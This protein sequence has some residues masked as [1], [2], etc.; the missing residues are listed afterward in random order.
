[1]AAFS[2]EN[3]I[4]RIVLA[5]VLIVFIMSLYYDSFLETEPLF[6]GK[7]TAWDTAWTIEIDGQT[8]AEEITLPY[9]LPK[10]VK[11]K[12]ITLHYTI[13]SQLPAERRTIAFNS[14]MASV[15]VKVNDEALYSFEGPQKGW[16]VPVFGGTYTHFIRLEEAHLGGELSITFGYTS[17]NSFAGHFKPVYNGTKTDLLFHELREWPSLFYGFSLL[18]IGFLV[19][20]FSLSIQTDEERKSFFYFGLVLLAL[21]GWVFSQT[22]SKFLLFR[23]PALPM[24]L[25]FAALFLLPL[26]LVNYIIH[27]YPVGKWVTP[28]LYISHFFASIYVLGGALQLFG[29]TQY[30]DLLLPCGVFLALFLL[31]LFTLLFVEYYRGNQD[32]RSFLVAMGLLLSSILAEV[33][34]LILGISLDSAVILHFGMAASAVV[35]FWRSATLMR[36][37][38]KSICKEQLLLSLAYSDALT[39]VGNRAAYDREVSRIQTSKDKQVLGILMMDVNDL[40][41]INDT[42][43]HTQG[44]LVLRD[45]AR[46]LQ[47]L[48]PFRAKIYRYGGDEFI[49]LISDVSEEEMQKLADRILS[50]FPFG[51]KLHYFVAV[52]FDRYIPKRKDRFHQCVGRADEAMYACKH[53]MKQPASVT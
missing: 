34:L 6:D 10:P 51:N 50:P 26:F 37:K 30:T 16:A 27:S 38:T 44:D 19:L 1:M 13:P 17:N 7:V 43:G 24:N 14:S 33:I 39:E 41:K 28:F 36:I 12:V 53:S 3:H 5:L 29:I 42:Q 21:G 23:N 32:L 46:R 31:S 25:S 45:F 18:L 8:F 2:R 9:S 40:K 35:L 4:Q 11:D 49:A 47:K 20:L 15:S 48:L 52:G 22:P